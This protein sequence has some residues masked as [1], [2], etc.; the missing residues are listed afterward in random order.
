MGNQKESLL[1]TWGREN[2]ELQSNMQKEKHNYTLKIEEKDAA[3]LK[4]RNEI[5]NSNRKNNEVIAEEEYINS[6]ELFKVKLK[7]QESL[8]LTALTEN[9][10][11][12]SS[13]QEEKQNFIIKIEEKDAQ[14]LKQ[15][16]EIDIGMKLFMNKLDIIAEKDKKFKNLEE[17]I[18]NNQELSKMQ[19]KEQESLLSTT[20]NE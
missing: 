13:M 14:I 11:L 16:N 18:I 10:K 6:K 5:D 9:E 7:E 3:I 20:R 8:L 17:D 19:L 1:S 2:E 12:Q 4:Q 15:K